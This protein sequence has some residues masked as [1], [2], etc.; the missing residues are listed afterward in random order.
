MRV[1]SPRAC[2]VA[3]VPHHAVSMSPHMTAY[4]GL[5]HPCWALVVS[6]IAAMAGGGCTK[7]S[8]PAPGPS[9]VVSAVTI[10]DFTTPAI[11]QTVQL[12][13]TAAFSDGTR[14]DVTIRATWTS[15]NL[16]VATIAPTGVLSGIG[17]GDVEIRVAYQGVADQRSIVVQRAPVPPPSSVIG[18][19]SMRVRPRHMSYCQTSGLR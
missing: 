7:A 12:T 17:P 5:A 6:L 4:F 1:S 15:S 19:S 11:G 9:A 3:S 13:A 14:Q 18:E 2:A 10:G 8:Q 16:S